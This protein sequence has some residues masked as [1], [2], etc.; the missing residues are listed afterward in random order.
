MKVIEKSMKFTGLVDIGKY[1]YCIK[2]GKDGVDMEVE[3][4]ARE[5]SSFRYIL[6]CSDVEVFQEREEVSRLVKLLIRHNPMIRIYIYS[7]GLVKPL[8]VSGN[9]N[10]KFVVNIQLKNV[11]KTYGE[12][13]NEN[14]LTWFKQNDTCFIFNVNDTN[15]MDEANLLINTFEINKSLVYFCPIDNFDLV[16]QKARR[17]GYNISVD[18]TE[19]L[20]KTSGEKN[21]GHAAS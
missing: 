15:D 8:G 14:A 17:Y 19:L 1:A 21:N 9:E 10:I 6:L 7:Y 5:V 12:R 18:V 3:Q 4:L 16:I 2:L 20:N 11:N 13:V